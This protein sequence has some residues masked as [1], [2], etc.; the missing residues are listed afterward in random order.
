MAV[1]LAGRPIIN[2]EEGLSVETRHFLQ[3]CF[4]TV[5]PCKLP[6]GDEANIHNLDLDD[7]DDDNK[8]LLNY[9]PPIF[10][11]EPHGVVCKVL[12]C[13]AFKKQ[14]LHKKNLNKVPFFYTV[15]T[16]S[17]QFDPTIILLIVWTKIVLIARVAKAALVQFIMKFKT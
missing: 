9:N 4:L 3:N 13:T 5:K 17:C 8:L 14:T 6:R 2:P 10:S 12:R 11:F 15:K 1:H 7:F 16:Q